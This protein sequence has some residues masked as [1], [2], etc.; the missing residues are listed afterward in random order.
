MGAEAEKKKASLP[1]RIA[2]TLKSWTA[3]IVAVIAL[4]G[5]LSTQYSKL[6]DG[7]KRLNP[8]D[9]SA[10]GQRSGK[11]TWAPRFDAHFP[12]TVPY[13]LVRSVGQSPD[14]SF[15]WFSFELKDDKWGNKHD[16]E[17]DDKRTG[18]HRPVRLDV[19]F[20]MGTNQATIT[21][22]TQSCSVRPGDIL[23]VNPT[24]AF[25]ADVGENAN[26]QVTWRLSDKEG[27]WNERRHT[28]TIHLLP[29]NTLY[30]KLQNPKT[31]EPLPEYALAALDAWLDLKS[32]VLRH[33][34]QNLKERTTFGHDQTSNLEQWFRV[35][36]S[37]LFHGPSA[38]TVQK[39]AT[40]PLNRKAEAQEIRT[41]ERILDDQP[42]VADPLEAALLL[43]GL[44]LHESLESL[45]PRVALYAAS[46]SIFVCWAPATTHHWQV[47]NINRINE[48]DFDA[49]RAA[50][51]TVKR[52][53]ADP[54]VRRALDQHGVYLEGEFAILDFEKSKNFY[55]IAPMP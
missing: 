34:V 2:Q 47:V 55:S 45:H 44:T 37:T 36:D 35:C 7:I 4:G 51:G 50:N 31:G 29:K 39:L 13:N 16:D 11:R 15:Y 40:P 9:K 20:T 5:I 27:K 49:N 12:K 23:I 8:L 3:V 46:D 21:S 24:F 1:E 42:R 6:P 53:L 26:M 14:S 10:S 19:D 18:W 38:W 32:D 54:A 33:E 52:K 22:K 30:W 43:G 17:T 25:L 28:E 48:V 41:L